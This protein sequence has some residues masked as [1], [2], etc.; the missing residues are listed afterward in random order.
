MQIGE[1][2]LAR[3][4]G[5]MEA[6][7]EEQARSSKRV[8]ESVAKIDLKVT[9]RLDEHEVRLRKLEV[10]N[11][12]QLAKDLAAHGK[13]IEAL[14]QGAARNGVIAGIGSAVAMSAL[15]ELAK[16]KLGL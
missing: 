9:Q 6:M 5:R 4:L 3:I 16:R 7:L 2:D 12:E 15:V 13:R 8:E 1:N 10:A 11:P 14:E